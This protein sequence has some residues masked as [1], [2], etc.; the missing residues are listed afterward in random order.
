MR[1]G[2]GGTGY[3][4]QTHHPTAA[5]NAGLRCLLFR[6]MPVLDGNSIRPGQRRGYHPRGRTGRLWLGIPAKISFILVEK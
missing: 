4:L 1:F 2:S 5:G 3:P 6:Q